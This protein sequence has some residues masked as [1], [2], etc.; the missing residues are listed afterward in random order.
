M[1]YHIILTELCNSE[2]RYC[3]AKSMCEENDLNKQFKFDF[4]A[5]YISA[6]ATEKIKKFLLRDKEPTLVFYGGEPLLQID[7]VK[8]LIDALSDVPNIKFRMQTN[9]KL[10]DKLDISYLKKIGKILVSIDGTKE[11][12]DFNKGVGTYDKV[13]ENLRKIRSQGYGGEI[14]ARM[15]VSGFSDIYEQ[16]MH[17][18]E[19]TACSNSQQINLVKSGNYSRELFDS[20]HWQLDVGFYTCDYDYEKVKK[21]LGKYNMSVAR[22][23]DWWMDEM[24]QGRVW[25][26]YPFIGLTEN[27]LKLK[28]NI[29]RFGIPTGISLTEKSP[30]LPSPPFHPPIQNSKSPNSGSFNRVSGKSTKLM[31]GAGHSG[32]TITTD[33]NL[34]AC[35]IMGCMP[36]FYCGDLDSNPKEL[37]KIHVGGRCE[38][39]EYLEECGGRCLYVNSVNLWPPEGLDLV[40]D[41][42]KHL[43]DSLKAKL[44]E[45]RGLISQGVVSEKDFEHEKY[46]G[47]EIVP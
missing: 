23:V 4:D 19:M 11:R 41:T 18:V 9:G 26:L 7:R 1:H 17:L 10:L 25:K 42:V 8:E 43:I 44:P 29:L 22:L 12:T 35:P 14:V 45:I 2:C 3:Y 30:P 21:W 27:L 28:E 5:P 20:I 24:R 31:C 38:N 37:K 46:F 16:V 32:Y 40:C 13:I 33:G 6:V 47:P 15:C 34:V 36:D 39:C